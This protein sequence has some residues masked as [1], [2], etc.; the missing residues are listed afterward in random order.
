MRARLMKIEV[1]DE[2][3]NRLSYHKKQYRCASECSV[4]AI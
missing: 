3:L 4:Y 1:A 2:V